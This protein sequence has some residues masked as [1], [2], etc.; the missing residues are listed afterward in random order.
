MADYRFAMT[1]LMQQWWYHR[2][3]LSRAKQIWADYG[4]EAVADIGHPPQKTRRCSSLTRSPVVR[5]RTGRHKPALKAFWI[6]VS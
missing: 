2:I 5:R 6:P 1:L 4:F 3:H